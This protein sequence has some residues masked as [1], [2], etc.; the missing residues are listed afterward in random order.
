MSEKQF[1]I[2]RL[3]EE[4]YGISILTVKE[5]TEYK[6]TTKVPNTPDFINGIINLRGSI[7]PVIDLKKRFGLGC[8]EINSSNRVIIANVGE[9]QVGFIVDEASQ[10]ISLDNKDIEKPPEIVSGI[11]RKYVIGV[12]KLSDEK[13]IILLDLAKLFSDEDE[14]VLFEYMENAG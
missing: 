11:D 3:G 1:V 4:E 7:I 13:I 8:E 5:I 12:G 6:K 9:K 10:V 2:F 14:K